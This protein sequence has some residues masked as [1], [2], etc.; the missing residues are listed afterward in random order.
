M[1][2]CLAGVLA[3]ATELVFYFPLTPLQLAQARRGLLPARKP[4]RVRLILAGDTLLGD[5]A[6]NILERKGYGYPLR[7]L[8]PLLRAGDAALV[9]LEGPIALRA[10][11]NRWKR[12]AY[13]M[14]PKAAPALAEAGVTAVTLANNHILDCGPGGIEETKQ[15]LAR[16]GIRFF[17]AGA[18]D[19]EARRPLVLETRGLRIAVL[20]Y[21]APYQ[22][23]SGRMVAMEHLGADRT[24]PG[25]AL[26]RPESLRA[27]IVR[28]KARADLVLLFLHMGDRYQNMPTEFERALVHEAVDTGADAVVACGTHIMGPLER[29]RGK[30]I[31]YSLG[32]FAFGS[33]NLR[34]RFSLVAF[35]DL[36]RKGV[37]DLFVVPIFTQNWNPMVWFQPKLLAG[38]KGRRVLTRLSLVSARLGA[39][40]QHKGT[41][42][43]LD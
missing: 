27:D 28:A 26:A 35:L 16:S 5:A 23:I 17:G 8:A 37:E 40:V 10:R 30:P 25:A 38:W 19:A 41:W 22:L 3:A 12:W 36:S 1:A 34:A 20:G 32:N 7:A 13:K 43:R 14:D 2:V 24:R 21:L 11:R 33:G 29:Y 18:D 39:R 31:A 15:Y 9:N 6:R 42:G 4:G